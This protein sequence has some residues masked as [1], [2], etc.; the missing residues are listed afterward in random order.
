MSNT[1]PHDALLDELRRWVEETLQID[2]STNNDPDA[3]CAD[4]RRA[5][6]PSNRSDSKTRAASAGGES[7][8]G[9]RETTTPKAKDLCLSIS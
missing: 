4:T 6:P 9:D 3:T 2:R 7:F 1:H 5:D 8:S